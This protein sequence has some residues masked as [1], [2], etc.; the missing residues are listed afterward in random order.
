MDPSASSFLSTRY[1]TK[2]VPKSLKI[3]QKAKRH[4]ASPWLQAPDVLQAQAHKGCIAAGEDVERT[5]G[6]Q[7]IIYQE[8]GTN[9]RC[10]IFG[11]FRQKSRLLS[12]A[13]ASKFLTISVLKVASNSASLERS[14]LLDIICSV[15]IA[16]SGQKKDTACE[17]SST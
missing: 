5:W 14:D 6:V 7:E 16:S 8:L 1:C 3:A 17:R 12:K 15:C 2:K 10:G 11:L 13:M 4:P 9:C